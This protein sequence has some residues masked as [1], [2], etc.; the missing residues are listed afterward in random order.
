MNDRDLVRVVFLQGSG[1]FLQTEA[2]PHVIERRAYSDD[3]ADGTGAQLRAY[4]DVVVTE[5]IVVTERTTRTI[6]NWR[7]SGRVPF[8]RI[9]PRVIRYS[10]SEVE[11]ALGRKPPNE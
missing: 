1:A 8:W 11:A 6:F 4:V 5:S 9:N 10:L 2:P 7:A 3:D